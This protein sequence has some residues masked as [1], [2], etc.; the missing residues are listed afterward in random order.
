[1]LKILKYFF[2]SIFLIMGACAAFLF[3][4]ARFHQE[5]VHSKILEFVNSQFNEQVTIGDFS[6][7]YL[8][9][10]PHMHIGLKEIDFIDAGKSVLKVDKV[11][12]AVNI[13]AL[14]IKTLL[15]KKLK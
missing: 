15:L 10:L 1:M 7:S 3:V 12:L 6:L 2:I 11:D 5:R 9:D 13:V 8:R 14:K 4:M